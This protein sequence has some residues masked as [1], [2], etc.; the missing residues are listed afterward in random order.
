MHCYRWPRHTAHGMTLTE[1]LIAALLLSI[2]VG[3][4]LI[5]LKSTVGF[6]T[7]TGRFT[8]TMPYGLE[9]G[10]NARGQVQPGYTVTPVAPQ[11]VDLMQITGNRSR[12]VIVNPCN[13]AATAA[14]CQGGVTGGP[15]TQINRVQMRV[16]WNE[17]KN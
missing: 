1:V 7:R 13:D 9:L 2:L 16:N 11:N 12:T 14:E 10:E 8:E 4:A 5:S 6:V 17:P 3:G 15:V